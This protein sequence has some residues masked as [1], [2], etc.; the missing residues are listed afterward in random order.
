MSE[1]TGIELLRATVLSR[2]KMAR[3][4]QNVSRELDI[5]QEA[6]FQFARGA[7][8]SDDVLRRLATILYDGTIEFNAATAPV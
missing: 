2:S 1:P 4:Y 5:G 7:L 8:L 3:F 6:L